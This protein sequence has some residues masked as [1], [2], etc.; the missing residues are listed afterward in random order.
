MC[1]LATAAERFASL[2]EARWGFE[3]Q[4]RPP[5]AGTRI[6]DR[7]LAEA[8][9]LLAFLALDAVTAWRVLALHRGER[10]APAPLIG[11]VLTEDEPEVFGQVVRK[12]RL[13]PSTERH[14]PPPGGRSHLFDAGGCLAPLE[15]T[16]PARERSA[17]AN[18]RHDASDRVAQATGSA[19]RAGA[20][21][22]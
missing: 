7:Q 22:C 2:Y 1:A 6:E 5:K 17:V 19:D 14:N 9:A 4:F 11:A 20:W 8:G 3:N 15:P 18:L 16:P 12:G 10:D 13:L 21:C